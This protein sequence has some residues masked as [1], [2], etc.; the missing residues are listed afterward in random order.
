[1]VPIIEVDLVVVNRF[2]ETNQL[3][4]VGVTLLMTLVKLLWLLT[5]QC[6]NHTHQLEMVLVK[7]TGAETLQQ[8]TS[9]TKYSPK[10]IVNMVK[11]K[12]TGAK[13][14]LKMQMKPIGAKK[15]KKSKQQKFNGAENNDK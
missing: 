10:S 11:V 12:L 7:Q 2:M 15:L 13:T 6:T 4:M 8:T 3:T 9:E 1:M 5:L 14:T